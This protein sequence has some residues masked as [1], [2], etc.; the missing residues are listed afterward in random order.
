MALEEEIEYEKGG[1]GD[2]YRQAKHKKHI[3]L[4]VDDNA[5]LRAYIRGALEPHFT[6]KEAANGREGIDRAGEIMPDLVISDVVMPETD[7]YELCA[8]LKT[9]LKTS[10]IPVILL[11]ARASE[12]SMVQGLETGA[13]D[14]ITKPF[15][16][17]LLA[18]RV[19]NLIRLRRQL[20]QKIRQ[21]M[22]LRPDEVPVSS[23]DTKFINEIKAIIEKNLSDPEFNV[24]QMAKKLYMSPKTLRRKVEALTGATTN[25]L[26]RSYRLTRALQLLKANFGNV[27]EVAFAV[28][29]SS[30]AYFTKCF[31]EKF[32]Q[33]PHTYQDPEA[34]TE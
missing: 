21:D 10:H 5:D 34:N 14:Y 16:T 18:I 23:I 6:I 9:D 20:Q 30:T 12:T 24:E 25:G 11:T 8:R 3:I 1:G 33:L 27:T 15:N 29:F 13:D 7:G 32:N 4:V 26:I 28:G 17:G 31:K 22:M 2:E 19:R